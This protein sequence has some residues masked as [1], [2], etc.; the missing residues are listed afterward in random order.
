MKAQIVIGSIL[1]VS[2]AGLTSP[3]KAQTVQRLVGASLGARAPRE[4]RA[5][6]II[7]LAK[8]FVGGKYVWGGSSPSSGGFDCSGL[9]QYVFGRNGVHLPR[10]AE[11]QYQVG[12]PVRYEELQPG[13]LI[14]QA[15]TWKSGIS[16]VGIYI[17]DGKILHAKGKA[18]GI[19]V[20][21]IGPF[22]QGHPG[23]RRILR[24]NGAP[25]EFA[26]SAPRPQPQPV[27]GV[28]FQNF[29]VGAVRG[30]VRLTVGFDP[31]AAGD[32][33]EYVI[34]VDG[35]EAVVLPESGM[36]VR[37]DTRQV[38]DGEH[39]VKLVRRNKLTGARFIAQL[40]SITTTNFQ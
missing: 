14:F 15:N 23:A 36:M 30:D 19:V 9:V 26:Y 31:V 28:A 2:I 32:S 39:V 35:E 12:K 4:A 38:A 17:G 24:S 3:A 34:E 1:V 33:V 13:D 27:R 8:Q 21:S 10:V 5:G 16:H 11:D 20:D 22:P 6:D 25:S 7:A 40:A 18:Y 37:F 29:P